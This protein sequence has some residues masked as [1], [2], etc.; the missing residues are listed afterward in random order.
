[1]ANACNEAADQQRN[2]QNCEKGENPAFI[3]RRHPK[4]GEII[5]QAGYVQLCGAWQQKEYNDWQKETE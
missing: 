4:H 1:M 3:L 2:N 5:L